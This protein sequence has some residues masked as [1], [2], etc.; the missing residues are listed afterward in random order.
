MLKVSVMHFE[1]IFAVFFRLYSQMLENRSY[2]KK[3]LFRRKQTEPGRPDNMLIKVSPTD[4][5][6][7][8][9]SN[10]LSQISF[11]K[12]GLS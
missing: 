3:T 10:I 12:I 9:F 7:P 2:I 8:I 11:F 4:F 5:E 1:H 6:H